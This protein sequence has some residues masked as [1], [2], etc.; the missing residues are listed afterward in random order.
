M[1]CGN[2][3]DR[4]ANDDRGNDDDDDNSEFELF[5]ALEMMIKQSI[6]KYNDPTLLETSSKALQ[7]L[8]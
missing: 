5:V 8:R 1:L 7:K 4:D 6:A 2:D 3:D